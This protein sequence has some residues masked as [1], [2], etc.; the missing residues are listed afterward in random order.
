MKEKL[1]LLALEIVRKIVL[2]L[3]DDGKLNNS[4]KTEPNHIHTK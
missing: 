4:Y 3:L 2:D 1:L